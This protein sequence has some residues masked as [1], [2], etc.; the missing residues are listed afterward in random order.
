LELCRLIGGI[1]RSSD[2]E[3]GEEGNV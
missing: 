1:S 3:E 2:R